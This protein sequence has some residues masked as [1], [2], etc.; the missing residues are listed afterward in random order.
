MGSKV[1]SEKDENGMVVY[2][3]R[4]TLPTGNKKLTTN[5]SQFFNKDANSSYTGLR[6]ESDSHRKPARIEESE[7]SEEGSKMAEEAEVTLQKIP[8][9]FS[10]RFGGNMLYVTGSFSNWKQWFMLNKLPNGEFHLVLDL[11]KGVY[12]YKFIVDGNWV[13]SQD[14]PQTD[15]GSGNVN[16]VVDN[17]FFK[18]KEEKK[19]V[20]KE[21]VNKS[22]RSGK[23][24]KKSTKKKL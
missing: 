21:L 8:T 5:L 2:P 22:Y 18:P 3:K 1:S 12:Q 11:P 13:C 20:C 14:F 17:S 16:N 7:E 6:S 4:P 9:P 10:W 23:E 19:P 15:D 24:Q